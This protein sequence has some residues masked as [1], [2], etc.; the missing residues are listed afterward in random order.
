MSTSDAYKIS[1]KKSNIEM[2]VAVG[3]QPLNKYEEEYV[4]Y[5]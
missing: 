5:E 2:L 4:L 3:Q 1:S